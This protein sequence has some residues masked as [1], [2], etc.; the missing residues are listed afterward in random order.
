[1]LRKDRE[2]GRVFMARDYYYQIVPERTHAQNMRCSL[3]GRPIVSADQTWPKCKLCAEPLLFFMQM[4][5][6]PDLGIPTR[7]RTH[8]LIFAC[9]R[10]DDIPELYK[11]GTVLPDRYWMKTRGHYQ[12]ILNP[13]P[14]D[15]KRLGMETRLVACS[16]GFRKK[17]EIVKR[18]TG[19]DVGTEEAK[20][21]GV[22]FW[23]QHP[24]SYRCCCG[25]KMVYFC[26]LTEDF[27]FPKTPSAPTQPH[28]VGD[29]CYVLFLGNLIYFLACK[30]LC[31]PYS[32]IAAVHN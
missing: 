23:I 8:L 21:G 15:E 7:E 22:P 6:K 9:W 24:V 4:D 12:I 19:Y 20:V 27:V 18:R 31:T 29:D 26:M 2:P 13:A 5:I 32:V 1:M 16:I 10:H 25:A 3:G 14:V 28:G 30:N 17:D 11:P